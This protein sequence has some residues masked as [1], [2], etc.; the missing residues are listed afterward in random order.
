M[1]F[2]TSGLR[3]VWY[4]IAESQAPDRP[5]AGNRSGGD[6]HPPALESHP[7]PLAPPDAPAH[8]PLTDSEREELLTLRGQI[9]PLATQVAELTT[10]SNKHARLLEQLSAA[11]KMAEPL[12]PDYIRRAEARNVGN[13]TPEA[14]FQTFLWA[15]VQRDTNALLSVVSGPMRE[16]IS[17]QL[18]VQKLEQ[19]FSEA[20]Q[21]P[22]GRVADRQDAGS[23]KVA[24]KIEFAPGLFQSMTFE[25]EATGWTLSQ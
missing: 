7:A 24:L 6:S 3:L 17:E 19:F 20:W 2:D 23:G 25:H 12:P 13:A 5:T 1:R 21:F 8:V 15:V 9:R 4:R 14:A 10:L 22:G 16:E 18:A 11:R